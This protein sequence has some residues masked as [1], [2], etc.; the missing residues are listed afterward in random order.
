MSLYL[1]TKHRT[2]VAIGIC[3]RCQMKQSVLDLS[4]DINSPGLRVCAGCKDLLDPY[5]LPAR[6]TE[7]A[8]VMYPR[9]ETPLIAGTSQLP[10]PD[11]EPN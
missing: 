7:P 1:K 10:V 8:T 6:R 3:D 4:A 11:G 5:K 2:V 9:P